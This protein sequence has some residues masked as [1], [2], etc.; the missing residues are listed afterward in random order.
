MKGAQENVFNLKNLKEIMMDL[1]DYL[2]IQL[3]TVLQKI[4]SHRVKIKIL[5]CKE[6]P[7]T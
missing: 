5:P 3:I 2:N 4:A 7:K 1:L 6:F